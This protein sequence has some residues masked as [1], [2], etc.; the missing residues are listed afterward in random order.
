MC[1][2]KK[3]MEQYRNFFVAASIKKQ[4]E[5]ISRVLSQMLFTIKVVQHCMYCCIPIILHAEFSAI[6]CSNLA[7]D[8]NLCSM[9]LSLSKSGNAVNFENVGQ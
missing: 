3:Y 2:E 5:Q 1:G 4:L 8:I 7:A 9:L 6:N